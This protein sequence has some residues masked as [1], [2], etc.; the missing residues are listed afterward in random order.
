M[1]SLQFK[2]VTAEIMKKFFFDNELY[3]TNAETLGHY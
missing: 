3:Q 2:S 1:A